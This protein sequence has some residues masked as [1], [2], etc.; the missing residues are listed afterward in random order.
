MKNHVIADLIL[1]TYLNQKAGEID[2][3]ISNG[4]FCSILLL[5][6]WIPSHMRRC[7]VTTKILDIAFSMTHTFT[8]SSHGE[9][10]PSFHSYDILLISQGLTRYKSIRNLLISSLPLIVSGASS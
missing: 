2:N 9:I 6:F 1:T 4:Y 7:A 5:L 3:L 10:I 8:T